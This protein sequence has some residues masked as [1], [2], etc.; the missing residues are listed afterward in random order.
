MTQITLNADDSQLFIQAIDTAIAVY[1]EAATRMNGGIPPLE[2]DYQ[3]PTDVEYTPDPVV[4]TGLL[5]TLR[6]LTDLRDAIRQPIS[7]QSAITV[8]VDVDERGCDLIT[9]L[10]PS[11]IATDEADN[12]LMQAILYANAKTKNHEV[13]RLIKRMK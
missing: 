9:I 10:V 12:L 3:P 7:Q 2:M 4:V 13:L 5:T 11:P 8:E 1:L 6:S